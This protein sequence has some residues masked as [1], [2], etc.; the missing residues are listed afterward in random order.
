[1]VETD[2]QKSLFPEYSS[3]FNGSLAKF[4]NKITGT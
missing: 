4:I 1:M 2:W 3:E